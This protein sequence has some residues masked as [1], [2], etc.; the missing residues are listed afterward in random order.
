MS[1]EP[2]LLA[3][4]YQLE[5][6]IGRGGMGEVWRATDTVL[7]RQVAVKT[8]DLRSVPDESGAARFEREA[9]VTAGMTHPNIVTVH[10]SGVEGDTAYLVMEL[11]PGP[12]LADRLKDGPLPVEEVER[13]G[14]DVA[15]ALDAAHARGLVHRDIKPG[16]IVYADDGRVR[17]LDFGITQLGETTG[18]Q[19]LTAT[20]TVM[21]TAEYL[22]PEQALG[23]RVDGRADLYALGCVLYALL[24]GSPPFRGPTPVATMMMHANDPVPDLMAARR[25]TP[26]W[27]AGL[28]SSLLAKDAAARPAGAASV[29]SAI[30]RREAPGEAAATTVLSQ[31][32]DTRRMPVTPTPVPAPPPVPSPARDPDRRGSSTPMWILA[33]V[34]VLA[35]A[36]LAW[37]LLSSQRTATDGTPSATPTTSTSAP[38]TTEAPTTSSAPPTTASPTPTVQPTQPVADALGAFS[39]EVSAL[40]QDGTLDKKAAKDLDAKARDL[41]KALREEDPTAVSD[42]MAALTDT[43]DSGVQDGSVSPD[44]SSSLD[45]LLAD[46]QGAVD[47]YAG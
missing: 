2:R 7:G 10:D 19:A 6:P 25:D 16:N 47:A 18:S 14:R 32:D 29:V 12:S 28:V 37:W 26:P 20:H 46:L 41:E 5:Q 27:L 45:P 30:E 3:D 11:L 22:A 9:R 33:V 42:A 39:D 44:A 23:G 13:V 34:A 43:Y 8:I 21:G 38:P 36:L 40:E 15:A 35:L 1:T 31:G 17:V 24:A 4:R